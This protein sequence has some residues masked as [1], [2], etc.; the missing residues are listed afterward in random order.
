MLAKMKSYK[1]D[2][3]IM[4][5]GKGVPNFV[6]FIL[7]GQCKMIETLLVSVKKRSTKTFYTLYN[8]KVINYI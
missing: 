5:D 2:E 4:G 1:V 7:S 3:T 8:P 6:Y